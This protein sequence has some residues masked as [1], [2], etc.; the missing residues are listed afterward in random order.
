MV[1]NSYLEAK[2]TRS[3][4][5]RGKKLENSYLDEKNTGTQ[6]LRAKTYWNTAI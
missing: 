1:G 5:F 3:Q 2:C 6:P 4:L